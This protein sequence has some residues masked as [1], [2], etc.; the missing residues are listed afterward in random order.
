M[1]VEEL[2]LNVY[3]END[4][5]IQTCEAQTVELKF[6]TIRGLMKLL[7]VDDIDDTGE[8]LTVVYGAWDELTKI[9]NQCF[10]EMEE[11]DWDNVKLNELIPVLLKILK[12]S[13]IQI[14]NIPT[15]NSKN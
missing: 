3:D 5:I 12:T 8:L 13:F 1:V 14:L 11:D 15:D 7:N 10:P 9:L 2:K 6:G 4:N